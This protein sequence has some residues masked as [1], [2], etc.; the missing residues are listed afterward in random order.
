MLDITQM[1]NDSARRR[2]HTLDSSFWEM[3]EEN[4]MP[5]TGISQTRPTR[6]QSHN[7]SL[8]AK[9]SVSLKDTPLNDDNLTF[10]VIPK[11]IHAQLLDLK[12]YESRIRAIDKLKY[13]IQDCDIN[14]ISNS[15]VALLISFLCTLLDDKNFTV[16]L[17]TLDALY[18][19]LVNLGQGVEDFLRPL[20][21]CTVKLLRDSKITVVQGYMKLYMLL[22]KELG[23]QKVLYVLMEN[24]KHKNSRVRQEVV[25]ICIFSLLTY[26]SKEF[27]LAFL[28]CEI[29]PYLIDSKGSV[30]HAALEAFAVLAALMGSGKCSLFKAVDEVELQ[31]TGDGLMNAV[32]ARLARKTLPRITSQGLVEYALPFPSSAQYRGTHLL[33]A[34]TDWLLTGTRIQSGQFTSADYN[35]KSTVP[36]IDPVARRILSAGKG[37]NKFPWENQHPGALNT[38]PRTQPSVVWGPD[39]CSSQLE[40]DRTPIV[41]TPTAKTKIC[42]NNETPNLEPDTTVYVEQPIKNRPPLPMKA[43]LVRLPSAHKDLNKSRPFPPITKGASSFPDLYDIISTKSSDANNNESTRINLDLHTEFDDDLKEMLSSLRHLHNSAAKKRAKMS[44]SLSNLNS[45]DSMKMELNMYSP[46][47]ASSPTNS[48]YSESGIYSRE[49]WT[50]PLSPTQQPNKISEVQPPRFP[51]EKKNDNLRQE[52]PMIENSVGIVGRSLNNGK[53]SM[54]LHNG[55]SSDFLPITVKSNSRN[56]HKPLKPMKE[57]PI[58]EKP[59]GIIGRG[60]KNR[61]SDMEVHNINSN[62]LLPIPV[63]SN[64]GNQHKPLK[65]LKEAQKDPYNDRKPMTSS[66]DIIAHERLREIPHSETSVDEA[67]RLLADEDWKK[68]IKGLTSVQSLSIFQSD[69]LIE[70]L[71]E[72]QIAVTKEV[73]NLRSSVSR[74]A[75]ICLGE[76]FSNLK[77]HMDYE[78]NNSVRV[79]LHKAGESSVFI[80]EEVDRTL[81]AMVQNVTPGRALA[82]LISGGLRDLNNTVKKCAA[83]HLCNLVEKMGPAHILSGKDI[84]SL[85]I[86]AIAKFALDGSHE[87]RYFGRK[88]L[89]FLMSHP[90]FDRMLEKNIPQRDLPYIKNLV[91]NIQQKGIGVMEEAISAR[92]R[93]LYRGSVS[94]LRASSMSGNTYRTPLSGTCRGSKAC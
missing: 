37:K 14:T 20:I 47:L 83:Q 75:I 38:F 43:S 11:E 31:E 24:L 80:R 76:M 68:K 49:S 4:G 86:P 65:P 30:R 2:A 67:L 78:L 50:S 25:N 22:M 6:P 3:K 55:N 85:A 61:N 84:T 8:S 23:P 82:S 19:L 53:G 88:M 5:L 28:A 70:R 89:H 45:P 87:T 41:K 7:Q 73:T 57:A 36:H 42:P 94:S 56:Q 58:S 32:Q 44:G 92:G 1:P 26:P 10:G 60:L 21:T 27:D 35:G 54:D 74:A 40:A 29:A 34:D 69:L 79:L 93:H 18:Y 81:N 52:A 90:H 13:L 59:V 15:N 48:S 72:L 71:H 16:V 33:G 12:D 17:G 9:P 39:Q 64:S 62:D 77:K 46:T 51:L 91:K 66:T 63:K